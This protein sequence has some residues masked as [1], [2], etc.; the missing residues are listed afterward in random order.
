VRGRFPGKTKLLNDLDLRLIKKLEADGRASYLELARA[1]D[2][3]PST[4]AKR[5]KKLL[6]EETII[7]NAVPNPRRLGQPANALIALNVDIKQMEKFCAG[8]KKSFHVNEIVATFGRFNLVLGVQF[9]S[10]DKLVDF[11]SGELRKSENIREIETFFVRDMVER[12]SSSPPGEIA[13]KDAV[14]IDET[15]YQL[16]EELTKNGRQSCI[17]LAG[18]LGISLSSASK[19]L[20]ALLKEDVVRIRA[21]TNPA[22]LGYHYHALVFIQVE[23]YNIESTCTRLGEYPEINRL[24]RLANGYDIYISIMAKTA[25]SLYEFIREKLAPLPGITKVDT[26][27]RAELIKRYY[28]SFQPAAKTL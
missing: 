12:P 16:I 24:I 28:G 10:W 26:L 13:Q 19:R 5:V 14:A 25:D 8:L 15:D 9:P 4:A 21:S 22:S 11:I 7:V 3:N 6:S 1:L 17:Y 23:S 18:K 2:I 27:I 20:A